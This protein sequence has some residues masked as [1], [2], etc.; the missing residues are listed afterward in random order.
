MPKKR[1][2]SAK[3]K[4]AAIDRLAKAREARMASNPPAY[5]NYNSDVVN[6]PDDHPMAFKKVRQWVKNAKQ[7][8]AAEKQSYRNGDNK[9]LSRSMIWSAYANQLEHYLRTGDFIG[10]FYGENMEFK[11][12]R[13]CI[14][15]AY[16]PN[17]KPKRDF[18]TWYPDVCAE[19]T[20]ELENEERIKFEMEPLTFTDSGSVLVDVSKTTSK[21]TTKKKRELTEQQKKALVERLKKAREA[22]ASKNATK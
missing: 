11:M 5:V 3:Q 17:G 16:H 7:R 4:A 20:P 14:A 19:W 15:M 2:M 10:T 6:L 22:K 13:R 21:K 18:G 9:A 1:T 8:S 12:K